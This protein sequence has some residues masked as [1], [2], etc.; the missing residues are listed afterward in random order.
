MTR[1]HLHGAGTSGHARRPFAALA[2]T[3]AFPTLEA[4][5]GLLKSC[6]APPSDA[7]VAA[8]RRALHLR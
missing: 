5:A 4:V 3:A 7:R 6:L 1:A 2:L 8:P